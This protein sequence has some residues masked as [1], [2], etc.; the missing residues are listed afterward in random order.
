MFS[1]RDKK[2][3]RVS[4][5][6]NCFLINNVTHKISEASRQRVI[7]EKRKNVHSVLIGFYQGEYKMDTS[8]LQECYYNPY[9]TDSFINK[10][11]SERLNFIG[12]VYFDDCG[13]CWI[14]EM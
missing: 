11:T 5:Y 10:S 9:T 7:R 3:K 14:V 2:N 1:I 4:A 12:T 13:K 8:N 6:G